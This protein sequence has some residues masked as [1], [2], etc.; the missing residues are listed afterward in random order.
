[1]KIRRANAKVT[2]EFVERSVDINAR[3]LVVVALPH[4]NRRTPITVATDR[5]VTRIRNPLAELPVL[6]VLGY[7]VDFLV[8]RLH[9]VT[10][11]CDANEPARHSAINQ[12][13]A[14]APTVR[15]RVLVTGH[16]QKSTERLDLLS[17]RL[18]RF[19][20]LQAGDFAEAR[21]EISAVVDR[22][23]NGNARDLAHLL[24]FF[25][26]SRCLVHDSRAI[27]GRDVVGHEN[28][29]RVSL[30][31]L[32]VGE[33]I[34]QAVIREALELATVK[35]ARHRG[36]RI[37]SRFVPEVFRVV[38]QQISGDEVVTSRA[39]A[40]GDVG[41]TVRP[42]RYDGVTNLGPHGERCV[43]REG[44]WRGRPGESFHA[45][46]SESLGP[47][48]REWERDRDRLVLTHLVDV[49]VHAKFVVR[50][51]SFVVPAVRKHAEPLVGEAFVVKLLE[52]PNH[53]L[54]ERDVE[55]L[56][57]I[58]EVNPA[59][60]AR[61]VL[62]PLFRVRQH[63]LASC[64]VERLD[65]H[66]LDF[67]LLGDAQLAHCLQLCGQTVGVP[68]E[69]AINQLAAHGL[70]S[71]E[72]VFGVS[73]QQVPVVRKPVGEGR[74][75]IED[76]LV[77]TLFGT[78]TDGCAERVITLPKLKDFL[79]NCRKRWGCGDTLGASAERRTLGVGHCAFYVTGRG[80]YHCLIGGA[81]RPVQPRRPGNIVLLH[82]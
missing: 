52:R 21:Q 23:T 75:V 11:I 34:P 15:V 56:I 19:E 82:T 61:D 48:T 64:R 20:Y 38:A 26:I 6:D 33:E 55:R 42:R 8:K 66:G 59:R 32:V 60:L 54:H 44:P 24:V 58:L 41:R 57:V 53:A 27:R 68:P 25:A 40:P 76:P 79:L 16:S 7:P 65:A 10:K 13:L 71:R 17:Q 28:L 30:V 2:L 39:R 80:L 74:P 63:R 1:M 78:L 31:F 37:L 9:A 49:V 69:S 73:G 35:F 45:G 81:L 36:A 5:P 18:V 72:D 51:R 67:V 70:V 22:E 12:W 43:C 77:G 4:W 62:F 47:L 50:K 46:Q 29:P 14:A 3:E